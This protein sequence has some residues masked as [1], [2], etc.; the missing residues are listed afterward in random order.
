MDLKTYLNKHC[1]GYGSDWTKSV[2]SGIKYLRPDLWELIPDDRLFTF[3]Q[4]VA[5]V[6]LLGIIETPEGSTPVVTRLLN[7][8]DVF[9]K[10]SES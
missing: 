6:E 7:G 3:N 1:V 2:L 8:E 5:L 10:P 9:Y 4:A